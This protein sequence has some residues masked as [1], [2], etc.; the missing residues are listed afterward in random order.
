MNNKR[1]I[2]WKFLDLHTSVF[3]LLTRPLT[4]WMLSVEVVKRDWWIFSGVEAQKTT[5]TRKYPDGNAINLPD[6]SNFNIHPSTTW[7][8]GATSCAVLFPLTR[9]FSVKVVIQLFFSAKKKEN[10]ELEMWKKTYTNRT[11]SL[12]TFDFPP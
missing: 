9:C 11:W 5:S 2:Y 6:I 10:Q 1:E 12:Y 8:S 3:Q 7:T 4:K